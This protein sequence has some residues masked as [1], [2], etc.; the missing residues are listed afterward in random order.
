MKTLTK[1]QKVS[2]GI[3]IGKA[4]LYRHYEPRIVENFIDAQK[5]EDEIVAYQITKKRAME[6]IQK[7]HD[8]LLDLNDEKAKIFKA[9]LDIVDDVAIDEEIAMHIK[10]S[11]Y[12]YTYAIHLVY[13]MF[14]EMFSQVE[15]ELTQER[16]ADLKDVKLRLLRISDG[17]EESNL[18]TFNE[19]KIVIANDLYPSDTATLNRRFVKGIITEVGGKTSHTAIIAKSYEIPAIL[20]V[21]DAMIDIKDNDVIIV[22][23]IKDIIVINPD[24]STL[25]TY[26]LIQQ[27]NLD[28]KEKIKKYLNKTSITKDNVK[29]D[30]S[31]NV[32]SASQEELSFEPYVD[33]IGLFRTEFLY[34][35][36]DTMPS[37]E[38]QFHV[39][40]KAL[41]HFKNK[42]VILRTL[43]IG[44]DK[45]LKYMALP[46]EDNPFL[47]KRAIRLCFD[48]LDM[49]KTQ[50]R[51]ALR[52]SV[53]G[54]L[55]LMFPMVGSID[56]ILKLKILFN[57]VKQ[58][59]DNENI[60]YHKDVKFG[61]MIEIPAL[62][63]IADMV[64]D[65][66]DFASIGTN[67]LT[68]YLTAVDRMNQDIASYYQNYAPSVFRTI[69]I[70]ADEFNQK[71]KPLS[72]CGELGGDLIGAPILAGLGIHKLSMNATSVAKIKQMLHHYTYDELKNMADQIIQFKS[73][74]EIIDYVLKS[75]KEK[76]VNDV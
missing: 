54:N 45:T 32:G 9:H 35:E 22:D 67:D 40:K 11:H 2:Q 68:Q 38:K 4:Y 28:Q 20:G 48:H 30:I 58:E 39:Y 26:R 63:M 76:G 24:E 46:K 70:I 25:N 19:D 53:F 33:G 15:D 66:V 47:G 52:A 72:V 29:I 55:W 62:I 41:S 17:V 56:D 36:S 44:G 34:M 49:F 74:Q 10:D 16:V 18:A 5:A 27:E 3:G 71:H 1:G 64:C 31:I 43:D 12:T 37:E 65:L 59:L 13:D 50:L 60:A 8:M 7:I 57:E 42:P 61:V 14:I 21:S 51:A 69:K 75:H 23:A 6:E 73:E